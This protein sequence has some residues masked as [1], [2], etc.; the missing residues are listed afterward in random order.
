MEIQACSAIRENPFDDSRR[1]FEGLMDRLS[2]KEAMLKTHSD[3]EDMIEAEGR[4]VLRQL[5]Q[6]HLTLRGPGVTAE[7]VVGADDV[8]RTHR[9]EHDRE[10]ESRFGRVVVT[11]MGYGNRDVNSLHPLDADLNLPPDLYSLGVRKVVGQEA[12]RTSFDE[13]LKTLDRYTGAHVPKRQAEKLAQQA[14]LD[15]DAFYQTREVEAGKYTQMDPSLVLALSFDGKGVP[16]RKEDLKKTTRKAA[17][18]RCPKMQKRLSKG[19]KRH[20]KRM[21]TVA[22]VY[23]VP[24]FLRQ[25][26]DIISELRRTSE[27]PLKRPR[28]QYKRIWASV[29]KEMETVV[30]QAFEEAQRRDPDRNW[31]WVVLVDGNETQLDIIEAYAVCKGIEIIVV[32]DLIHVVE[33]LWEAANAFNQEGTQ[34]AEQWVNERLLK[35]LHGKSSDVAAGIRRSATLRGFI[36]RRRKAADK[37]ANYLIKYGIYLR[38]NEYLEQGLPIASG[39][40]EGGCRY[41]VKD[42]MEL[43]GARW[44][45]TSAEAVLKLRAIMAS[46]DFEDYW[47]FHEEREH[48]RNH[49]QHYANGSPPAVLRPPSGRPRLRVVK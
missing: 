17:E 3:L 18:K 31:T 2:S 12:G 29:E 1:K 38:Y 46:G 9:R 45:L 15:F 34:E 41:L 22:A 47:K 30:E 40:I 21:A 39:V 20:T 7:P 36:G 25:P 43:T 16:M 28:P 24:P 33:Y 4:E 32:L 35:I 44:R 23:S 13:V 26:E 48:Q 6:D 14:A 37:C 8:E 27:K 11:R 5:L 19:E 10:L 49:A 42:R